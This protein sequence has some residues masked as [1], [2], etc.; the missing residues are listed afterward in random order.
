MLLPKT[1]WYRKRIRY[2]ISALN[3]Y[4][5]S[6]SYCGE[7]TFEFL[8]I[9]HVNNDGKTDR[10]KNKINGAMWEYLSKNRFMP[11][12]Y[13]VLCHNC[14]M[15][16]HGYKIYPGGNKIMPFSDWVTLSQKK[17]YKKYGTEVKCHVC[18][19]VRYIPPSSIHRTSEEY[20][21]KKCRSTGPKSIIKRCTSCGAERRVF[22][23]SRVN[24]TKM[25][26]CRPC[27][28]VRGRECKNS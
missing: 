12:K 1:A 8:C 13:Q 11:H 3:K 22:P 6:C 23:S 19:L 14:N 18:S 7:D 10:A 27:Y 20:I 24:A 25:Y 17:V 21:C 15:A 5:R 2:K 16:K 28:L 4:G 26:R 9:D